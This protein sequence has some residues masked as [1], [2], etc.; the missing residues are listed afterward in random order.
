MHGV[1]VFFL[2][3]R[4]RLLVGII[5]LRVLPVANL[6]V[7]QDPLNISLHVGGQTGIISG[8][9]RPCK[10]LVQMQR[11]QVNFLLLALPFLRERNCEGTRWN[12]HR[13]LIHGLDDS[14]VK[15]DSPVRSMAH[16]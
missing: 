13:I 9:D 15:R 2:H 3:L 6:V 4:Q 11:F 16:R 12:R 1:R 8:P 5:A 7:L 10:H 14:A